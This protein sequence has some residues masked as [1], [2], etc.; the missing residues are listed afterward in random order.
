MMQ[1]PVIHKILPQDVHDQV[2][3]RGEFVG[4]RDDLDDGFIHCSTTAQLPGTLAKHFERFDR[5][6]LLSFDAAILPGLIWE[7]SR[8]NMQ[9]PHIYGHLDLNQA[10]STHLLMR[11]DDGQFAIPEDLA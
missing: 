6:V 9:F 10:F 4:W 11:G 1:G 8:N 5:V 2:S 3:N 7:T